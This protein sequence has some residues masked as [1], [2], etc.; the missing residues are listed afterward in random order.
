MIKFINATQA[1]NN[2]GDLLTEVYVK[3]NTVNITK[4]NKPI[5]KVEPIYSDRKKGKNTLAISEKDALLMEKGV[6]EFRT[7]FKFSF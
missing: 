5:V 1:K 4:R 7:T 6:K 2:F 3:G